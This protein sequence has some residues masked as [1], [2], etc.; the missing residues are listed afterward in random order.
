MVLYKVKTNKYS[1]WVDFRKSGFGKGQEAAACLAKPAAYNWWLDEHKFGKWWRIGR[2]KSSPCGR[3]IW[4]VGCVTRDNESDGF[5][6]NWTSRQ[7]LYS[8][9]HL[10]FLRKINYIK[11]I[12]L[13]VLGYFFI[14]TFIHTKNAGTYA[15]MP[16]V[17]YHY[18][19]ST[20]KILSFPKHYQLWFFSKFWQR[21]DKTQESGVGRWLI[22][23][24]LELDSC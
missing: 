18:A 8:I 14:P 4:L 19:R 13:K 10:L 7:N 21:Y 23:Q 20:C 2:W 3:W 12:Y 22:Y 24:P 16:C 9:F 6:S 17:L 1:R 11:D 5:P 15:L